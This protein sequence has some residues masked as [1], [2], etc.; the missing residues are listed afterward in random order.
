MS[1]REEL[2]LLNAA[3]LIPDCDILFLTLDTL[4][5]DVARRG[6]AEGLTP[7]LQSLI[8]GGAWEERH[9]P[10]NFTYAAHQAF[11][12]GFLPTPSKP[13]THS[14]LFAAQ[15]AGSETT[16][17]NTCVFA[18]AN[19]VSG[20]RERGY[21]TVCIGGVGFFNK[22]NAL[23]MVLPEL[24]CQSY[25][26]TETGVT[27]PRSTENQVKIALNIL[28]G[29]TDK[30]RV[31]M[32]INISALHQPNCMYV[33]GAREDSPDTQLQAL[34]YVD[35]QLPP[36][37]AV[38]RKRAPVLCIICSDHGTAYGEDGFRGHRISHPVVWTVPYA[39]FVLERQGACFQLRLLQLTRT[40]LLHTHI[41]T[42]RL[43]EHLRRRVL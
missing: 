16:D 15:F 28:D 14:R 10:G 24:F 21:H 43:T 7:F 3:A 17:A 1:L 9:S 6:I 2:A 20:L 35:S 8:P 41:C 37:V 42:K 27:D 40:C 5:F 13:G 39:E 32:F 22:Q 30:Q 29:L 19:I 23:G 12:A 34:S 11:F 38:M 31:F 18:S 26:S 33:Q 36:L 4:R 25:W